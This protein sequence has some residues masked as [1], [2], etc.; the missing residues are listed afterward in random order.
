MTDHHHAAARADKAADEA[1]GES[2]VEDNPV[3][4]L[5]RAIGGL[6]ETNMQKDIRE[7]DI[8]EAAR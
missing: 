1:D 3:N 7:K 5:L 8:T 2:I 4:G 6:A